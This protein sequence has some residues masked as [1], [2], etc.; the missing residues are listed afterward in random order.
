MPPFN[1]VNIVIFDIRI[2]GKS[3]KGLYPFRLATTSFIYP[4]GYADNV[5]AI[6][7]FVDEIELL[8]FETLTG[9][10]SALHAEVQRLL[11]LSERLTLS[12]NVHLPTDVCPSH[13]SKIKR[14]AAV[15]AL[16]QVT[17]LTSPLSPSTW[18]LH[19]PFEG[20]F[21]NMEHVKRWQDRSLQ[22][23]TAF[24]DSG[25][26]PQ[27]I[28][29]ETL[30]Y[31]FELAEPIISELGLSVCMDVGHHI[32]HGF[33]YQALFKRL[34]E[35]ITILHLHGVEGHNDH[36]SLDRLTPQHTAAI[37][38]VL[39][40]FKGVASIEVFSY[41]QLKSSLEFLEKNWFK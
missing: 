6:G 41:S 17:E 1:R 36:L 40:Q 31:P 14:Q 10:R 4:A 16:K 8:F 25:I 26:V 28:S 19:L 20:S 18:T 7:P 22:G 12:F 27:S 30:D 5:E 3:Y 33:D 2:S 13:A 9:D 29:V 15:D 37:L 34:A 24:L 38:E 21:L 11:G 35:R 39:K 23:V 32:V